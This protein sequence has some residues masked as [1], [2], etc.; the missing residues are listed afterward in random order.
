VSYIKEVPLDEET[1]APF[2]GARRMFGFIPNLFRAQSLR[3]DFIETQ[4][5][6]VHAVLLK[7]GALSRRQK[8][9]VFLVCSAANLSTYCVTAHCEIVRG[10]KLSGPEP[11]IIAVDHLRADIPVADK[12]LLTF[13]RKLNDQ[14]LKMTARDIEGLRLYGF[15]D[16]QILETVAVA[17]LAKFANWLSFGL[18]S[19]PDFEP[20]RLPGAIGEAT[21][22]APRAPGEKENAAPRTDS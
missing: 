7:E 19:L 16:E 4:T 2:A 9:Y 13:A 15:T 11:E 17:S 8:E 5:A 6:L 12:M 1:F 3:P 14:P 18:G 21:R 10:L 22:T 20:V